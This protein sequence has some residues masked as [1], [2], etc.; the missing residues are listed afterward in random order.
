M[1]LLQQAASSIVFARAGWHAVDS[2]LSS[3]CLKSKAQPKCVPLDCSVLPAAKG[4]KSQG[5]RNTLKRIGVAGST[6]IDNLQRT[7]FLSPC[8]PRPPVQKNHL[9]RRQF[10]CPRQLF[11][12]PLRQT[13]EPD[14]HQSEHAQH[15]LL[16]HLARADSLGPWDPSSRRR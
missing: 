13:T 11:N 4:P 2:S 10:H 16:R 3:F 12:Q 6:T 8:S 5:A 15:H 7:P 1:Q 9:T 14:N